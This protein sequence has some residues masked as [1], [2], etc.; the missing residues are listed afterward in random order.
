M[1]TRSSDN[2]ITDEWVKLTGKIFRPLFRSFLLSC[3]AIQMAQSGQFT[4]ELPYAII[5]LGTTPNFVEQ[6]TV[7][8][9]PNK[10][11]VCHL[12]FTFIDNPFIVED[13]E[14]NIYRSNSQFTSR[15]H[16]LSYL[17]SR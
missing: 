10:H 5:G 16:S 13:L 2:G 9:P 14:S 12:P 11:S 15:G 7:A 6:I 1:E 17:R 4:L 3:L 8:V